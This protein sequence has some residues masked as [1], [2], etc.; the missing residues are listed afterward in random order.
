MAVRAILLMV[1]G[2]AAFLAAV[3]L[4]H[5]QADELAAREAAIPPEIAV[6]AALG[7][8]PPT[9]V[10]GYRF[11]WTAALEFDPLLVAGP[12]E[13]GK[14]GVRWFATRDGR[15]IYE[16]DPTL[17]VA[18]AK[19]PNTRDLQKYLSLPEGQRP[20]SVRLF[21]WKLLR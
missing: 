3:L 18:G 9:E 19:G 17:F 1:L 21:G 20:K 12:L 5:R 2:L 13:Y 8:K 10:H 15:A 7:V 11:R 4:P 14:T 6:R 16:Y